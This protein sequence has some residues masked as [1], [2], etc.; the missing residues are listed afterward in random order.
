MKRKG[1]TLIEL[2]VVIAIIAVLMGILMPAL[3]KVKAQAQAIRCR[4]N[5]NQYGMG[6]RMYLDDNALR[7]PYRNAWMSSEEGN[8]WLREGETP[9]GSFWPYV[10]AEDCHMC[11]RFAQL[12]KDDATYGDTRVSYLFNSYVAADQQIWSNWLGANVKGV[13]RETEVYRPAG[14]VLFAEENTFTIP[15]YS[16][17]PY[18][19]NLL[20][21]GN[22]ARTI[23]NYATFHNASGGLENGGTNICFV[24]G[25]CEFYRRPNPDDLNAGFRMAWPKKRVPWE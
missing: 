8:S 7:F 20:T 4:A 21:I 14:V 2:L 9:N 17:Y 3:Q 1:F 15:D 19:D 16:S 23:D 24:D 25:H 5:L 12:V 22:A 18:N 6:M 11:P 10:K 13:S